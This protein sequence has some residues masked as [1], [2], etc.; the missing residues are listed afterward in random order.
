M[1]IIKNGKIVLP[2]KILEGFDLVVENGK[3][4]DICEQWQGKRPA[5]TIIDAKGNYVSPGF[6]DLHVHGGGEGDFLD[7][8][9]ED[10]EAILRMHTFHG[11]TGIYPTTLACEDEEVFNSIDLLEGIN[12]EDNNYAEILGIHL[13]GP[14]LCMAQRGA[15]DPKYIKTPK[16]EEY[17]KTLDYCSSIKRVT[18]AP[19]LEGGI[20]LADELKR[21]EVLGSIGH[22]DA[23]YEQ[24]LEAFEHGVSHV[25]HLYSGMQGVHR[26]KGFRKLGVVESSYLID[27]MTVEVIADGCHLPIELLKLI[28]KIKGPD[29]I[30]LV[31]DAMRAAGREEGESILGSKENG[32]KVILKDGVAFMPDFEAFAGSIATMDRLVRNMYKGVQVPLFNAVKM[33]ALTPAR[34]MGCEDRK[35][36]LEKGKDADI[37]IFDENINIKYVMVRGKEF[38]NYLEG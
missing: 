1:F 31:T 26:V 19:E 9:M 10:I 18:F 15:Q 20:E 28:Y 29:K 5:A 24:V 12:K 27:D 6:I 30:A 8:T 33:A 36:S 23:E 37:L 25:T 14:Y 2:D 32:Q 35:G 22:S 17:T 13:E 16:K 21:R 34:I 7:G 4:I 38:L 3:I 11:T